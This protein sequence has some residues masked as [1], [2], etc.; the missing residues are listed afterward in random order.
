MRVLLDECVPRR[1]RK[2]FPDHKVKTVPEAR[3]SGKKNG[4]LLDLAEKSFDVLITVDQNQKYQQRLHD[5]NIAVVIVS[6]RDNSVESFLPSL[7]QVQK[8]LTEIKPGRVVRIG[9]QH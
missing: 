9:Q 4:Q 2:F 6:V 7:D 8:V 5:R 3:W 1:L